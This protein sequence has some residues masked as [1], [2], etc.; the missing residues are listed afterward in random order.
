MT[1]VVYETHSTSEHNEAG[2]ATG[3]LGGALSPLGRAQAVELGERRRDD[4]IE[5]VVASDLWRAVE[6]AAIAF[7]GSE[8]P[9][10]V[11]WRLRECDYGEL[12]GMPRSVLDEQRVRHVDEPWPGGESWQQAVARVSS[13]LD[14]VSGGRVLLIGH[15]ATRWALDQRV[16]GRTLEELAAEEFDWRPGWEYELG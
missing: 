4:G 11:D 3:W 6:T 1:T 16:H 12:T 7:E 15:V 10:R 9:L 14:E 8:L 13:F 2:I 5:V